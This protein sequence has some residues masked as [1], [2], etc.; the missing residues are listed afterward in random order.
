[1]T[2]RDYDSPFIDL[3]PYI[4]R[5]LPYF[6]QLEKEKGIDKELRSRPVT[7]HR[8]GGAVLDRPRHGDQ[9]WHLGE[10]LV[11]NIQWGKSGWYADNDYRKLKS[12]E[13]GRVDHRVLPTSF[14]DVVSAVTYIAP[15]S[16]PVYKPPQVPRLFRPRYG[17]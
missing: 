14:F 16:E 17:W 7:R 4:K 10:L 8:N 11:F 5:P 12:L 9:G 15:S 1:M 3:S 2:R 6:D 13:S